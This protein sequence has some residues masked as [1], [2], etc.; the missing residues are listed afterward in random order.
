MV[1]HLKLVAPKRHE[2]RLALADPNGGLAGTRNWKNDRTALVRQAQQSTPGSI[3]ALHCSLGSGRQWER[4]AEDAGPKYEVITPDISGY[5]RDSTSV[6]LPKTL[7]EEI[8]L[9]FD[10]LPEALGPIHLIG[11]SYGGALALKL[12]TASPLAE[13]LCS[14][15]LIEPVLPTILLEDGPD[16]RLYEQFLHLGHALFLDLWNDL[17]GAALDKF[18][19]FW[20]GSERTEEFPPQQRARMIEQIR[21][22]PYQF[23]ALFAEQNIAKAAAAIRVPTLLYSGGL[24]PSM[25]Q[26][27]AGRLA[28]IIPAVETKYLPTAGHMIPIS[29]ADTINP[30]IMRHIAVADQTAKRLSA[31][32]GS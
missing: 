23:T 16:R 32:R 6:E 25:T 26:R 15:T 18:L 10:A 14:L 5:G 9:V 22:L 13:R 17:P 8:E 1:H 11:H 19:R 29:H 28:S 4:L 31:V 21:N 2:S 20:R 24:S 12:A 3:I 27:I 7:A 30:D